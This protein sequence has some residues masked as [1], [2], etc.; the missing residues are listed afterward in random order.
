MPRSC[1]T[2]CCF[3]WRSHR[4]PRHEATLSSRVHRTSPRHGELSHEPVRRHHRKPRTAPTSGSAPPGSKGISPVA[5]DL[6]ALARASAAGPVAAASAQARAP[7]WGSAPCDWCSDPCPRLPL[8][9]L[10]GASLSER[11]GFMRRQRAASG[12]RER[13][14]DGSAS[15]ANRWCPGCMPT[16]ACRSSPLH[17]GGW[18]RSAAAMG[19]TPF[20]QG[21]LEPDIPLREAP[22]S[23]AVPP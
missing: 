16:G 10:F 20:P 3:Q 7:G 11:L 22:P 17:I 14:T 21:G 4:R 18:L 2:T 23:S 19:P 9:P 5:D 13:S 15:A 8:A 6:A 1:G 12:A